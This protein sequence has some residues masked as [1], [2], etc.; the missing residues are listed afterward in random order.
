MADETETLRAEVAELRAEVERLQAWQAGHSCAA[1]LVPLAAPYATS[2]PPCTCGQTSVCQ[3]HPPWRQQV[4]IGDPAGGWFPNVCGANPLPVPS[5]VFG[6]TCGQP[7][8][9]IMNPTPGCADQGQA[10]LYFTVGT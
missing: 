1:P 2:P 5:L 8:T 7:P 10:S 9:V 6:T 4:T 3:Q